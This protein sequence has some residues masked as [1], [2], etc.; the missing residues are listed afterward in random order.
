MK[1]LRALV[2]VHST[3]V[4]PD[5]LKG[6]TE[7]EI[8]EWRTE[9]DVISHLK[10]A[11]HEVMPLGLSDSLSALRQAITDWQPDIVFNLLEEF[12]GIVTYDQHVVAF[13]ELM[14][15]PYTGCNP[16]GMLLSRDKVLCK[17]LLSYHRVPTPQFMVFARGRKARIPNK[18]RFP[19]FVKS[20]TEDASL[21]I[22]QASVVADQ[23]QLTERIEFIHHQTHSDAL[24]EE[25]IEG[26]ELYV[27][28]MGNDRLKVLPVWEMTFGSL[29]ENLPAIATRKVK[30]DRGYQ[31]RYGITTAAAKDLPEG[32][33]A[34]LEQLS[35]R[36]FRA[37]HL[38]GYARMDFRLRPNGELYVL[39]A[40]ANPNLSAAED[41]SA[42]A[43]TAGLSY[44]ELLH[45]I[46]Q[47]GEN[48]PAAWRGL[49]P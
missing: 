48:Y 47:L 32:T 37:L 41:F 36:I 33:A 24:V 42:S 34:R 45:R 16:R 49:E 9:Y 1:K 3:L 31:K 8:E 14:H 35:K 40:N 4:P 10:R 39:E 20:S 27:G 25:Y 7:K 5:S 28:V 6:S 19:L 23:K 29:P 17:Q 44:D 26:R 30:W 13:L 11:G 22:A 12:D 21:G 2:L 43:L 38:T 46:V 15:Q 18:L